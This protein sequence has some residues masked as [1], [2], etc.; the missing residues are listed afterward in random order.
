MI[1][2][3]TFLTNTSAILLSGMLP[4]KT[5]SETHARIETDTYWMPEEA[6]PHQRTFMQWPVNTQIH[7]DP[8]FL[9]MLQQSIA[10][11][12]NTIA[13]FEPVV[14]LMHQQQKSAAR[15]KLSASVEIWDVPTDD[16]WCRDAGPVFVRN[17]A[18]DLAVSQLNFNGWGGKQDHENDGQIAA[19]VAATLKLPVFNNGLVGEAGGVESD[20]AG[21]LIAHE[22]SWVNTNRN[23]HSKAQIERQ[24]MQAVGG[25]KVIWAPGIAGSDIT[26]YH[27]DSLARFSSPGVVVIQLPNKIDA[28]DPWSVAAFAT[29]DVLKN[30]TDHRGEKLQ[31]VVVP[32][33]TNIRVKSR[34]FVA[35]YVNY[36]VCNGAVIVAQFGDFEADSEAIRIL[37]LLYPGR[38]IVALNVDPIG[39]TG[40]GIHCATQQQPLIS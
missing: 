4:K 11:I 33:P 31:L 15:S 7:P 17:Q 6:D 10:D 2:K 12:A 39:E 9:D 37:T 5:F 29:Y 16:L 36:Y 27:I 8:V 23:S 22:S 40:G 1:S 35:S 38:E 14:M 26:D 25:S 20:G 18:G 19:R 13:E 3:R 34:D 24:L 21:T 28:N 32:E 30:A